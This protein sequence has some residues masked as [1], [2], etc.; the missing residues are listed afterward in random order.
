VTFGMKLY[1]EYL[2]ISYDPFIIKLQ[3]RPYLMT[4]KWWEC[5]LLAIM[6]RN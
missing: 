3:T 1:Y 4:I 2:Q 6:H 5:I